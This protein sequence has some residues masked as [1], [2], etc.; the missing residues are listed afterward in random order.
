MVA[1]GDPLQLLPHCFLFVPHLTQWQLGPRQGCFCGRWEAGGP[2]RWDAS[3]LLLRCD[4]PAPRWLDG[5]PSGGQRCPV[6]FWKPTGLVWRD[7]D[8]DKGSNT[9]HC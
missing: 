7:L 6:P 2:T 8:S 4:P 3:H 5:E 1:P 9:V